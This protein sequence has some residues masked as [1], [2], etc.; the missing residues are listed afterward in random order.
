MLGICVHLDNETART[1]PPNASRALPSDEHELMP[2]KS[3]APLYAAT[4]ALVVLAAGGGLYFATQ[5]DRGEP[6]PAPASDRATPAPAPAPAPPAPAPAPPAPAPAPVAHDVIL[7]IEGVPQNTEILVGGKTVGTAPGPVQLA[8]AKEPIV[9]VLKA[10]GYV[11]LSRSV[12]PDHDQTLALA[13]TKK[14]R[15]ASGQKSTKDDI[16]DVFGGNGGNK[17]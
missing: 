14:P 16:I 8:Q 4:A 10:D 13:L 7:T 9:L 15:A 3:R 1:R 11:P 17:K 12:V 2:A 6:A 5:G